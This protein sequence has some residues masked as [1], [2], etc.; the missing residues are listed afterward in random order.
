MDASVF[1]DVRHELGEGPL[2]HDERGELFWFS[3]LAGE[4]HASPFDA[5]DRRIWS[6][7]EP[8]SAAAIVDRDTLLVATA[9]GLERFDIATGRR[10]RVCP[11]DPARP[12]TRSNDGRGGPGGAFWIGTMGLGAEAG[13]G[14]LYRFAN[15]T[16]T[17]KRRGITIPNAICF[18]PDGGFAY[19]SDS[20]TQTIMR[21]RL[22]HETGDTVGEPEL[23]VDLRPERLF[24]DGSVTDCEGCVWNAQWGAGRV[25]RYDPSGRFIGAV[26][27]PAR[28]V[29]CPAFGGPDMKTLFVTSGWEH[30]DE[31]A[32]GGDPL[33]GA[34]FAIDAG[35]A[36]A[37]EFRVALTAP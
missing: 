31:G 33:A 28:Q 4:L 35:V 6:F 18:A 20:V 3:I 2:W 37:P 19:F 14:S 9:G 25:A 36:G 15:G 16:L 22:D 23:F 10:T 26:A 32:R 7:G 13:A 21:W 17:V 27:V 29:T 24:P 8:A 5:G 12:A 34:V 11:F 1:I 30:M